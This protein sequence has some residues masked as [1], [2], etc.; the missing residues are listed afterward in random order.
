MLRFQYLLSI[1]EC[2]ATICYSFNYRFSKFL[3]LNLVLFHF[4][5]CCNPHKISTLGYRKNTVCSVYDEL[6][7][8][9]IMAPSTNNECGC[10]EMASCNPVHGLCECDECYDGHRCQYLTTEVDSLKKS[11]NRA[12]WDVYD[13]YH[14]MASESALS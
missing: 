4:I 8:V 1:P 9:T 7:K 13:S 11:V 2:T 5:I 14:M 12:L 10:S 3:R 6:S